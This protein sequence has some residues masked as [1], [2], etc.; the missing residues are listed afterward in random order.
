[1]ASTQLL[2]FVFVAL[3]QML[4]FSLS[5]YLTAVSSPVL[6][7]GVGGGV[8]GARTSGEAADCLI[9]KRSALELSGLVSV[10]SPA[11]S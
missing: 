6:Q 10:P 1:M 3:F 8:V 7:V 5:R 2:L 4:V 11:P 9:V